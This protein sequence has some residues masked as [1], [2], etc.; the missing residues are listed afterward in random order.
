MFMI[1]LIKIIV[2]IVKT[3]LHNIFV[4]VSLYAVHGDILG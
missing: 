3:F 4:I 2:K 1:L